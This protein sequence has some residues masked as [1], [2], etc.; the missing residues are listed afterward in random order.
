MALFLLINASPILVNASTGAPLRSTPN[1]GK[2]CEYLPSLKAP[3]AS[4]VAAVTAPCPPLHVS[5]FLPYYLR[6]KSLLIMIVLLL[7]NCFPYIKTSLSRI[8]D[9]RHYTKLPGWAKNPESESI[10]CFT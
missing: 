2:A 7:Y 3:I 10:S 9:E 4:S 6:N 8:K 5:V 1:L